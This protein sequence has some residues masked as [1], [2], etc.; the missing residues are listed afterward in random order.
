MY[1]PHPVFFSPHQIKPCHRKSEKERLIDGLEGCCNVI[2]WSHCWVL[3]H[4]CGMCICAHARAVTCYTPYW[5]KTLHAGNLYL[6]EAVRDLGWFVIWVPL[7]LWC[8]AVSA[9]FNYR[10]CGDMG[11]ALVLGCLHMLPLIETKLR[12]KIQNGVESVLL[13]SG[14]FSATPLKGWMDKKG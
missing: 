4:E 14:L 13:G 11:L 9:V 12:N 10:W 5:W 2:L 3:S 8:C 6:C 7:L 1:F